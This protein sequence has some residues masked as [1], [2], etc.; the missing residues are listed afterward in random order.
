M[1]LIKS[2]YL[3]DMSFWLL[4]ASFTS[5][6]CIVVTYMVY[7]LV[8]ERRSLDEPMYDSIPDVL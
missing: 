2:I 3:V 5:S 4:V 8:G 1:G 7:L 6:V